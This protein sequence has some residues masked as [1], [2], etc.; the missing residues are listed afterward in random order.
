MLK[1]GISVLWNDGGI[2]GTFVIQLI[3]QML[4]FCSPDLV[5]SSKTSIMT[6]QDLRIRHFVDSK[7]N[8]SGDLIQADVN[9]LNARTMTLEGVFGFALMSRVLVLF[10]NLLFSTFGSEYD[11]SESAVAQMPR[12]TTITR[13]CSFLNAFVRWDAVYFLGIAQNRGYQNEQEFA[14]F[15]GYPLATHTLA[16]ISSALLILA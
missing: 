14:F 1:S 8:A 13:L 2:F 10:L 12:H 4:M 9:S 3:R 16:Q 7:A 15:P 11:S 6:H 5:I